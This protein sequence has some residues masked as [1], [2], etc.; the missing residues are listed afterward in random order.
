MKSTNKKMLKSGNIDVELFEYIQPL[1]GITFK[2]PDYINTGDGY[3][4]VIHV[5]QLPK[6]ISDFWLDKIFNIDGTVVTMDIHTKDVNEVK[7]NIKKSQNGVLLQIYR[8]YDRMPSSIK[9]GML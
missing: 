3:V 2:E 5:C 7:K 9:E 4:K 1:G 6:S 8:K